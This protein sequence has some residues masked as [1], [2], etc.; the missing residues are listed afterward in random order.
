[1]DTILYFY[2]KR[3]LKAPAAEPVGLKTYLLIR[4]GLDAEEGRWFDK[5]LDEGIKDSGGRVAQIEAGKEKAITGQ[6]G[7]NPG[8]AAEDVSRAVQG[9]SKDGG[10]RGDGSV[11]QILRHPW[12]T[13]RVRWME[14][15]RKREEQARQ[16]ARQQEENCR[17]A[18]R[19]QMLEEVSASIERLA[20]EVAELA[21]GMESCLCAYEDSLRKALT[22]EGRQAETVLYGRDSGWRVPEE[23]YLESREDRQGEDARG[24]GATL[25]G[26]WQKYFPLK[27]FHDYTNRFWV[28]QLFQWAILPHF[29]I[30]GT[31]EGIF[32]VIEA[33]A[34]R[35]KSM[36]W[37]LTQAEY[38]QQMADFVEDF[39]TEYGLAIE[40]ELL[41]DAAALKRLRLFCKEAVNM[42]DFTGEAYMAVQVLPEGSIWLDMFSVEEKRRRILAR[43][44]KTAY[45]SLKELWKIAQKRCNCPVLP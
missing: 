2:R 16:Y 18:A 4:V 35:M 26:L 6:P 31:A 38:D 8:N 10:T 37:I 29:I 32:P 22:G 5:R 44:K 14:R 3:G 12:K 20:L 30:L 39:Y 19:A 23:A 15:K 36:R 21:G 40:L 43:D 41:E 7:R 33:Y 28:E 34:A 27:E 42:V 13:S 25:L 9:E 1:M 45:I 17:L 24:S 11:L